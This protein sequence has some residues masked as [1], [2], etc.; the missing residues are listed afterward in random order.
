MDSD[1]QRCGGT[2]YIRIPTTDPCNDV[3][4]WCPDCAHRYRGRLDEQGEWTGQAWTYTRHRDPWEPRIESALIFGEAL[5][6]PV[7]GRR[8]RA[9]WWVELCALRDKLWGWTDGVNPWRRQG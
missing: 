8:V 5:Y 1:C 6:S 7:T 4:H 9:P 3:L 2:R